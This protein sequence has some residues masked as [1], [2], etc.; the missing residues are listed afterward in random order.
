MGGGVGVAHGQIDHIH[1]QLI[2]QLAYQTL[3]LGQIGGGAAFGAYA[4][5]PRVGVAV[6]DAKAGGDHKVVVLI[7][8]GGADAVFEQAEAVFK[9]A[10]VRAGAV[11]G[12]CQLCQQVAVAALDVH[13]VKACFPGKGG[14]LAELF[15]QTLQV[16]VRHDAGIIG[17]AVLLQN[18]V[19]VGDHRGGLVAGVGVASAVVRLHDQVRRIAVRLDAGF[20]DGGGHFFEFVQRVAGQ[21][22]L[23]L[24]R[25]S[26]LHNGDCLKP[27]HGA[28]ADGFVD[29]AAHGVGRGG[30]FGRRV[31]ALHGG[32]AQPVREGDVAHG[33]RLRQR[34]GV[35]CKGQVNT[36]LGGTLL[37]FF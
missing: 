32:D 19:A 29:V 24:G 22:Q 18:R 28:A 5:A 25:S 7:H 4:E 21:Q 37:D 35:G 31:R 14:C 9:A 27:D 13:R 2:V 15:F 3:R 36:Q 10:A 6:V 8:L 34:V 12:G 33:Q 26:L 20:L 30:A 17:G 11:V 1:A 16:V 23:R